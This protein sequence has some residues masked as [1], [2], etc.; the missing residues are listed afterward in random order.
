M[1]ATWESLRWAVKAAD[2]EEA[3]QDR[4]PAIAAQ[5]RQ[6]GYSSW[7]IA[8]AHC[9]LAS[10]GSVNDAADALHSDEER[11]TRVAPACGS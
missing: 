9:V 7:G 2:R 8:Q 11:L 4:W 10:G 6:W 1:T 5:L 3:F